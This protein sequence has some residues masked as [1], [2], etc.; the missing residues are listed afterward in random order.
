MKH[1]SE[2]DGLRTLAVIPVVIYH[3]KI[4][5][6]SG[7]FLPGGFLGVDIFFVISGF[8]ITK[9]ILEEIHQT[10][11]FS[12]TNFYARRARR[13][14]PALILVILA[15]IS[16]SV[17]ILMP[18]ELHR[19]STSVIA[20]LG[21]A[22]NIYWYFTLGEYGAQSGLLQPLLH[23]WSLAIEE[24]FYIFFP[25]LLMLIKPNKW[26]LRTFWILLALFVLSFFIAEMTTSWNKQFSFYSPASRAWE[27]LTGALLATATTCFPDKL[28]PGE[29][30]ARLL[31]KLSLVVLVVSMGTIDFGSSDHPGL[32]TIPCVLATATIIWCARPGEWVTDMLST[33]AM[34]Y[35]GR[36]SYSIYLWHFP[37]FAFGRLLSIENPTPV[38]MLVWTALT[39]ACSMAGYYLVERPFRVATRTPVFVASLSSGFAAI[40]IFVLIATTTDFLSRNRMTDLAAIYGVNSFDNELLRDRSWQWLDELAGDNESIGAWNAHQP[41]INEREHLWFDDPTSKK[42]LIVGNS[43]S[44]DLFNALYS[45]SRDFSQMEFARFGLA[46]WFP[47]DQEQ[48]L[49]ASPNFEAADVIMISTRYSL[50]FESKLVDFINRVMAQGKRVVIVGNTPEFVSPGALPIF[51]WYIRRSDGSGNLDQMNS[52]AFNSISGSVRD[53]DDM[54]LRIAG[55]LGIT[56]L[57][58]HDLVCS[59]Q[60]RSCN[61]ITSERRKTMYDY[62]HWTLE[63]AEFFG[64][65]AAQTNWL[66][67][68]KS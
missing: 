5:F 47:E 6:G 53:I 46:N 17:F 48:Q 54:L 63:G 34:T 16:V 4:P 21:F 61:L 22:S 27:L 8:L 28:I 19:F 13:I 26:P 14:L 33:G 31:P 30:L 12:I 60:Q 24:Q 65:R 37:I 23:T 64:R 25:L 50:K 57:S 7:Y 43:H 39:M 52:I 42:I 67:P 36:L 41:S 10:G 44:K 20:S 66:G 62:G 9:L 45:H 35:I 38:D 58:R 49:F 3:L 55:R 40:G 29:K 59:D 68:L 18:S 51:D 32:V 11:Q 2:I 1:R 15:S 56:Y